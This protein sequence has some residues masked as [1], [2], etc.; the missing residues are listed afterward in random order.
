VSCSSS[1]SCTIIEISVRFPSSVGGNCRIKDKES[2]LIGSLL[3]YVV[4]IG[5]EIDGIPPI[6]GGS[7]G[8]GT[9]VKKVNTVI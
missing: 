9:A 4:G 8:I 2:C 3:G 7:D 5:P 1:T 6:L